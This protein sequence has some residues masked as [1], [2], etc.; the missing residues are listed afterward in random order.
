[1]PDD[2]TVT[3]LID[4]VGRASL[5]M[6]SAHSE[7]KPFEH[8]HVAAREAGDVA[9]GAHPEQDAGAFDG[10]LADWRARWSGLRSWFV[11]DHAHP[12]QASLLRQRARAAVPAL[13]SAVTVLEVLG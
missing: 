7:P 9:P 6:D 2:G 12:S 3:R 1:M 8:V 5:P 13:L 11:G 10:K 4:I